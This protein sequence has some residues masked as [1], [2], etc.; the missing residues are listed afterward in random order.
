MNSSAD[1]KAFCGRARRR[2]LHL[3]QREVGAGV[4]VPPRARR[5][6]S[7]PTSTSGRNTAVLDLGLGL[8]DCVVYD[9]HRRGGGLTAEQL[10]A[11]T[12]IL[13]KGHC[14]VHGRF[15]LDA[16]HDVRAPGARACRSW[17]TPSASTRSCS[18]PTWSAR[19]SSSS[20][21]SSRPRP[22]RRGPSAPSSTWCSGSPGAPGADHH[23]PRA[24][25]LLLRDDEPDRP[26]APGLGPGEPGRR[27]RRQ[28][29]HRRPPRPSAYALAALQRML[30]LPGETAKD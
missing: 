4:G 27:P 22:A 15:T 21:P 17:C 8:D 26:A 5:C 2:G 16:V 12:V 7:C 28:P 11:A 10:R 23:V 14:S 6:C 3:L 24:A 20:R 1:I 19:P 9:P 18:P 30:E 13:W 29:D 25:R